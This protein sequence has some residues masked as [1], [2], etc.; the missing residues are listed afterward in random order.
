MTSSTGS[1]ARALAA[2]LLRLARRR[3]GAAAVEFAFVGPALIVLILGI[4]ETGRA[5]WVQNALNIAVEQAARCASI[6]KNNCGTPAQVTSYAATVSGASFSSSTFTAT[7]TG[8]GNLVTAAYPIQL[9]I[10]MADYAYTVTAQ[11][12][13]PK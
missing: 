1:I 4:A 6:D 8:C 3:G 7:Q 2:R 10:P 12:C 9:N 13:Y 11:S 5:L